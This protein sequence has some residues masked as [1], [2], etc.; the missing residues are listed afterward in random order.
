M[1]DSG[2]P[3]MPR[4][5][6]PFAGALSELIVIS[7]YFDNPPNI[8]MMVR[9]G[10]GKTVVR[11]KAFFDCTCGAS[12]IERHVALPH[13]Y[14]FEAPKLCEIPERVRNGHRCV[15]TRRCCLPQRAKRDSEPLR[16]E[17]RSNGNIPWQAGL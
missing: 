13:Q 17:G 4:Q 8:V 1:S 12:P 3:S 9:S 7:S 15:L 11:R 10:A 14:R 5:I 2:H 16:A 6:G